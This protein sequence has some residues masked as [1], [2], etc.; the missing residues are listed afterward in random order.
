M[1]IDVVITSTENQV[2][3]LTYDDDF[4][5]AGKLENLRK[6]CATLIIIG[7]KF[8][9]YP[10]PTKTW[11]VVKPYASQQTNKIFSRTKIKI[12]NEGHKYFRGTSWYRGI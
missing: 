11:L 4:S 9:Y 12:T 8:G 1:L 7:P 2:E 3:V 6:W 5:A 10:E